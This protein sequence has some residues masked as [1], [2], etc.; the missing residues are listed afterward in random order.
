MDP[1]ALSTQAAIGDMGLSAEVRTGKRYVIS[2]A[3]D[4]KT[5][6]LIVRRVLTNGSIEDAVVGCRPAGPAPEPRPY[7]FQTPLGRAAQPR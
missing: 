1:V 3:P 7:Q 4:A 5:V 6:D 2:P